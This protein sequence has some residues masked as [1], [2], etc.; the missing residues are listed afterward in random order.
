MGMSGGMRRNA[1]QRDAM[2]RSATFFSLLL[3]CRH[4]SSNRGRKERQQDERVDALLRR[5]GRPAGLSRV[6]ARGR[7]KKKKGVAPPHL[8]DSYLHVYTTWKKGRG[9]R[10]NATRGGCPVGGESRRP[11]KREKEGKERMQKRVSG[12]VSEV[13][14]RK[15]V[16]RER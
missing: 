14:L 5:L 9:Q 4:C 16:A 15:S 1:T 13:E 8:P 12:G 10:K 3:S 11:R 2:L 6:N 7:V